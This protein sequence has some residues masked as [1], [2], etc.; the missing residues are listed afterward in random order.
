MQTWP[1]CWKHP[2]ERGED[3][4]QHPTIPPLMETPP[5]NAGKTPLAASGV[6][7]AEKHPRECGEDSGAV[8]QRQK[9]VETPPRMR[10]RRTN[11]NN[12]RIRLGNTPANAGKTPVQ[13]A[14]HDTPWKHP[15]ECG[16]DFLTATGVAVVPETP[17]RMRGRP[18][19]PHDLHVQVRN[20]PA[21]AGKTKRHGRSQ[22]PNQKH[23]RECGEDNKVMPCTP[24]RNPH[25][26]GE[27][28]S[29]VVKA[30]VALET[31][32]RTRGRL[33]GHK[34]CVQRARNTPANAG[35]TTSEEPRGGQE[36]QR[37]CRCRGE[38]DQ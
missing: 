9:N 1:L 24:R 18:F 22:V 38:G 25:E 35:K 16:E 19:H 13:R 33:G 6:Q 4:S 12:C 11:I 36:C 37:T 28:R 2:R 7:V 15:R 5:A 20:T 31:P 3:S 34:R 30:A 29:D 27:D 26:R 14:H 23:P 10:G 21:N 32:P 17:P 8:D